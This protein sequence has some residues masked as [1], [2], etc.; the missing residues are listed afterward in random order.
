MH[1]EKIPCLVETYASRENIIPRKNLCITRRFHASS[2]F[3]HCEK[4]VYLAESYA[5]GEDSMPRWKFMHRERISCLA[6]SYASREDFIPRRNLRITGRYSCP[7][8]GMHSWKG[9]RASQEK[10][11]SIHINCTLLFL[12]KANIKK[13][14]EDTSREMLE[15]FIN[16]P[17]CWNQMMNTLK[18]ILQTQDI[19][20]ICFTSN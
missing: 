15:H 13:S 1:H 17:L 11:L 7:Q 5:S 12:I 2:K 9:N 3:I 4:I 18:I 20:F 16:F 10:Y 19:S 8:E 6:E 14:I